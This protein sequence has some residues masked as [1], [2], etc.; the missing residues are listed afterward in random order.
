V[1]AIFLMEQERPEAGK[2]QVGAR[3]NFSGSSARKQ[4]QNPKLE[5]F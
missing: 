2:W 4:L 5:K 3:F 1:S